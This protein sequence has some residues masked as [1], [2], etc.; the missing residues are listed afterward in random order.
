MD[1]MVP[2]VNALRPVEQMPSDADLDKE[3]FLL[4]REILLEL[5]ETADLHKEIEN[6]IAAKA[7]KSTE[8]EAILEQQLQALDKIEEWL[9]LSTEQGQPISV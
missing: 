1:P 9:D 5:E 3:I 2:L 8:S 4:E 6:K 7:D